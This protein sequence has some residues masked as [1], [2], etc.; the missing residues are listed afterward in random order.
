[1]GYFSN[2]SNLVGHYN[3]SS[4]MCVHYDSVEL[5]LVIVAGWRSVA[6]FSPPPLCLPLR[7]VTL[8]VDI[9]VFPWPVVP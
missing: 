9:F 2:K 7:G 1:M 4:H 8:S 3:F 6:V 5:V